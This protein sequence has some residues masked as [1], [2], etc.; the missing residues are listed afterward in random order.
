MATKV[1]YGTCDHAKNPKNLESPEGNWGFKKVSWLTSPI[2]YMG[3]TAFGAF[4]S[5]AK[6]PFTLF[7]C[8][9]TKLS[10]PTY[11]PGYWGSDETDD[12][13]T[14]FDC[15]VGLAPTKPETEVERINRILGVTPTGAMD[16]REPLETLTEREVKNA[17]RE[18]GYRIEDLIG[19]GG[20]G[21]VYR[22]IHA[23]NQ[24]AVK[25]V[26]PEMALKESLFAVS[27]ERGE[28]LALSF[29]EHENLMKTYGIFTYNTATGAYR[30]VTDRSTCSRNEVV[31]GIVTEFVDGSEELFDYV[32]DRAD[33]GEK[34]SVEEVR[35]IGRQVAMAVATMHRE[36]YLHRD[37]KLENVLIDK[38]GL[39][40][41][42]D[43]GFARFLPR[44]GSRTRTGLGTVGYLAPEIIRGKSYDHKV[45]TW[46]FGV[47]LLTLGYQQ[48]IFNEE[49]QGRTMRNI[50]AY[51][52]LETYLKDRV[53]LESS[54]IH[55]DPDFRDL[56]SRCLD[57][58][59][60]TRISMEE[61]LKH[62]FFAE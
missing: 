56:V 15:K 45:D 44:V 57:R 61:V 9:T 24:Y 1:T 50:L 29:P 40:K 25:I 31:V 23:G 11:P 21:N 20:T 28:S 14:S 59:P 49:D 27:E 55:H 62:R 18:A 2:F 60:T 51:T 13:E 4:T 30:Y 39:I 48:P 34:M 16:A 37:L 6:V 5:L 38:E 52:N 7:M 10:E 46:A 26:A 3:K 33:A 41:L 42:I 54:P 35:G 17:M 32:A 36:S 58:N 8:C 22:A 43:F 47:L 12:D 53:W 19:G